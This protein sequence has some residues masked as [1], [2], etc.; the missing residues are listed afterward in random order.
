[1][2]KESS[3]FLRLHPEIVE[4]ATF[5]EKYFLERRH[6]VGIMHGTVWGDSQD[7]YFVAHDNLRKSIGFYYKRE[8]TEITEEEYLAEK[9]K[10]PE[11]KK[12]RYQYRA[13]VERVASAS[14]LNVLIDLGFDMFIRKRVRV[15]GLRGKELTLQAKQRVVQCIEGKW[16]EI[17]SLDHRRSLVNVLVKG[18]DL[19]EMIGAT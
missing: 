11:P 19:C 8:F 10:E 1:M 3:P 7:G 17:V 13:K 2:G 6:G 5:Y 4:V 16:I 15:A 14:T 12:F 9:E 18:Q